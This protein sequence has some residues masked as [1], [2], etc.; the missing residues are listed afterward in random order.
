M[1]PPFTRPTNHE[2]TDVPVPS[3]AGL[4]NDEEEQYAMARLLR[5]IRNEIKD[6][7][8]HG[9]AGL[10]SN[11]LDLA[12]AKIRPG[13]VL[14]LVMP[15]SLLQGNAWKPSRDLLR[16]KYERA[17]VVSLT[18]AHRNNQLSFS[19]DTGMRE[20]LLIARRGTAP[21]EPVDGKTE[22]TARPVTYVAIRKPPASGTEATGIASAIRD[23]VRRGT[24]RIDIGNDQYGI[25]TQAPGMT[26]TALRWYTPNLLIRL[27]I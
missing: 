27:G 11:F 12:D 21:D 20:V 7:A 5:D 4:G 18:S 15:L 9:N 3:F 8:G 17:V 19:A 1:N 16:M 26:A 10:A 2:A 25:L 22:E 13:G 14:A 23:A 6:P 24:S